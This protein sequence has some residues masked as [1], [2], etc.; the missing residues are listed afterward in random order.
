MPT[1]PVLVRNEDLIEAEQ[2][3][4]KKKG[5]SKRYSAKAHLGRHH[6]HM[7]DEANLRES[8]TKAHLG[9]LAAKYINISRGTPQTLP[10]THDDVLSL[11]IITL[12]PR[13]TSDN[14]MNT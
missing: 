13:H 2:E 10:C 7:T 5:R 6:E 4:Q 1:A 8:Q 11:H 12:M 3:N 14:A 9:L